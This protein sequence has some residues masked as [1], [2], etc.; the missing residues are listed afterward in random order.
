M[1]ELNNAR[2]S[3]QDCLRE[4][5]QT[6]GRGGRY[7]RLQRQIQ[8][9]AGADTAS[10]SFNISSDVKCTRHDCLHLVISW[11]RQ[12]GDFHLDKSQF[13]L[14]IQRPDVISQRIIQFTECT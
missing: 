11:V 10:C 14:N 8:Q 12:C 5:F 1:K 2:E 4:W 9:A 6:A 13:E 7:D 3:K